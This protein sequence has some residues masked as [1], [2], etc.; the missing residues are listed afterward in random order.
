MYR[1]AEVLSG[2]DE[3]SHDDQHGRRVLP[4]QAV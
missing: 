1:L 3:E 2:A 4:I